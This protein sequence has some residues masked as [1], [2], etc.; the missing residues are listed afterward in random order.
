MAIYPTSAYL[1]LTVGVR[2]ASQLDESGL[3][4]Q[5]ELGTWRFVVR[6]TRKRIVCRKSSTQQLTR[7]SSTKENF[8]CYMSGPPLSVRKPRASHRTPLS[9]HHVYDCWLFNERPNDGLPVQV[10]R[11][12]AIRDFFIYKNCKTAAIIGARR[13]R[14]QNGNDLMNASFLS[15]PPL[16]YPP[17]SSVTFW[18]RSAKGSDI[19]KWWRCWALLSE[20]DCP[21]ENA[22]KAKRMTLAST[23]VFRILN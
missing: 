9:L 15:F 2:P 19:M 16:L 14:R 12:R 7:V 18:L 6:T 11:F 20:G 3:T 17:I 1:S 21:Q 22:T 4:R 5:R 13:I 8:T 23:A 10:N